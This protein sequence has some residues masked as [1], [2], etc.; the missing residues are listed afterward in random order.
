[1]AINCSGEQSL[2]VLRHIRNEL[3]SSMDVASLN[4]LSHLYVGM[5]CCAGWIEILSLHISQVVREKKKKSIVDILLLKFC[6]IH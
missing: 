5:N 2:S 3:Q 4:P 1:M 6:I